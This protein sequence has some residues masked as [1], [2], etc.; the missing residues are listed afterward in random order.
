M[1]EMLPHRLGEQV[2]RNHW[3]QQVA[4]WGLARIVASELGTLLPYPWGRESKEA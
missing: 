1:D 2:V 3:A 4:F